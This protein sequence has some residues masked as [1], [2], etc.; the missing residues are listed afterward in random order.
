MPTIKYE[1]GVSTNKI[2]SKTTR[3]IE[4]DTEDL[5]DVP[6]NEWDGFVYDELGGVETA[7]EMIDIW[8]K[9]LD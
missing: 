7:H 1:I 2:G 3:I 5:E 4:I 6:E 9:R 8:C